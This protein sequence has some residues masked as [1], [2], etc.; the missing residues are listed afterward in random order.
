[1][2]AIVNAHEL[3]QLG[4]TSFRVPLRGPV[5]RAAALAEAMRAS[6]RVSDAW[7]T[8][9]HLAFTPSEG[10]DARSLLSRETSTNARTPRLHALE[11]VL[12][13]PDLDE[14]ARASKLDRKRL[15]ALLWATELSVS[16]VGFSPGFPYLRGLDA[17][18][19]LPRR[20]TPRPRVPRGSLAIAGGF[21]GI[22]PSATAGGWHLLGRTEALLFDDDG[23]LLAAGDRVHLTPPS[24]DRTLRDPDRT[25]IPAET[26]AIVLDE[27]RGLAFVQDLGRRGRLH[28]GIPS[29]GALVPALL[30]RANE[31]VGNATGAAGIERYGA[32]RIRALREVWIATEE[33]PARKLR[34]GESIDLTWHAERRA[35][36]VAVSGGI[37]VP[38]VLGGRG[39]HVRAGLGG[40]FGRSLRRGDALALGT[41]E[42]D[43]S[44][45][46]PSSLD[47]SAVIRVRPGPD[48]MHFAEG[49]LAR[50]TASPFRI[51]LSSDRM[52][53]RLEGG[54][55]S[56]RPSAR[57]LPSAPLV[58][59]AI[60]VP[61][62]GEPIVL[63]PEHPSTG[64]YPVIGV[65]H[66]ADLP[67][68]LVRPLGSP[69]RFTT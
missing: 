69:V 16:F 62:S 20:S 25:A 11:T 37:D 51:S 64:G 24:S 35:G 19:H 47:P 7:H 17:R 53:C 50:L 60:E 63:G 28:Q 52:G 67:S 49:S 61:P 45:P 22:Y 54:V 3:E 34:A 57:D 15:A 59:G 12:D 27:V 38:V 5:D 1:M 6:G 4:E 68:L 65:V 40:L 2:S 48:L 9:S 66:P 58:L 39:T 23:P 56:V 46:P 10:E 29:S 30:A 44:T 13:G 33:S 32:M 36:Y 18:L 21:A 8:E 42:G 14:V 43:V 55:L 31:A 41:A 26:P